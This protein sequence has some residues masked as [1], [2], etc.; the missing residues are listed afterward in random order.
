[1][2]LRK[3]YAFLI[4][5]FKIIHIILFLIFTYLVFEMRNIYMFFINYV[6][7]NHYTYFEN[8]ANKYM[9]PF[10]FIMIIL[11]IAFAI[12]VYELMKKKEKPVLFYKILMIE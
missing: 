9:N 5:H 1:M 12:S 2:I 3:P 11:I 4:K 8:M 6:K 7:N 10:I